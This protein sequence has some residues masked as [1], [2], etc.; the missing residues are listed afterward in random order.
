MTIRK[1]TLEEL[2]GLRFPTED[3]L[4]T[5]HE[6]YDR[7]H[8]LRSAMAYTNSQ[9]DDVWIILK[10]AS[11]DYV[12]VDSTLIDL[13]DNLVELRGGIGIPIIAIYDVGV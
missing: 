5:F 6:R 12:E 4:E 10:S 8:K 13:Q 11:G 2:R 1:I 9:H 3:V 7:E